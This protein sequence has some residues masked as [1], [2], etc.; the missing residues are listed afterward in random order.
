MREILFRGKRI[1]NDEWVYGSFCMDALEQKNGLC[2]VDGFIRLY[3]F[4][5]GKSQT[6]Q[7]DRETVGQYT[8]LTDKNGK[9][10]FEGDI[11]N[12]DKMKGVVFYSEKSA[13][14]M[15]RWKNFSKVRKDFFKEC[16]MADFAL[17]VCTEVIGNIHD[18]PEL[19]GGG[20]G[21]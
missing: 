19:L 14:F 15:L 4:D 16:K 20:E 5:M 10:I 9:K 21:G 13:C 18:N 3:D 8:G 17:F 1:D 2:G 6:H 7:V 11:L 12:N